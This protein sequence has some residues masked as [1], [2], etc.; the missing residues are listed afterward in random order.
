MEKRGF[1]RELEYHLRG[2]SVADKKDIL[3]DYEDHFKIGEI[4]GKSEQDVILELGSPRMIAQERLAER[5]TVHSATNSISPE[6]KSNLARSLFLAIV[7]LLFN[8]IIMLG[9]FVG[10]LGVLVG[11]WAVAISFTLAPFAWLFSLFVQPGAEVWAEFFVVLTMASV[12]VLIGV[13]MI[14]IT[15]VCYRIVKSYIKW[16]VR[17]IRG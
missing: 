10:L 12:G 8:L 6:N 9:P 4:D 16:N 3:Q 14:F 5:Q 1:M 2:L 13:A 15:K 7:L 17:I 11:F